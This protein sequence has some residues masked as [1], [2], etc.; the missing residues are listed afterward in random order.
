MADARRRSLVRCDVF[1]FFDSN[2]LHPASCCSYGESLGGGILLH[3]ALR[4]PSAF[5]GL[6]LSAP[7]TGLAEGMAPPWIVQ[8]IGRFAAWVMPSAAL[9]PVRDILPSVRYVMRCKFMCARRA[10][11]RGF[12]DHGHAVVR[13]DVGVGTHVFRCLVSQYLLRLAFFSTC[14]FSVSLYRMMASLAVPRSL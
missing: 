12:V 3:A 10:H 14:F 8:Q 4:N 2:V 1:P 7:M 5:A 9:A 6:V 13:V 11:G